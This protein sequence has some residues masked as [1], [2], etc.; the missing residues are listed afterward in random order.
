MI[1]T[2][3]KV[4][5][6]AVLSAGCAIPQVYAESAVGDSAITKIL[7]NMESSAE[8]ML[9]AIDNKDMHKLNG[10]YLELAAS[11]TRMNDVS[12]SAH[13]GDDQRR[14]FGLQ[15]SW[16]D[17]ISLELNEMDDFPALANAINQFSG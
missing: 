15:N 14:A 2:V 17:L 1:K 5:C 11:M 9:E 7:L 8:D 13:I 4:I 12:A 3:K 16:F 10:L 6:V